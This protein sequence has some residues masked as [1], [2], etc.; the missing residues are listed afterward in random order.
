MGNL[1]RFV[2][3]VPYWVP[4]GT[5]QPPV[6]VAKIE[7]SR[8]AVRERRTS[9]GAG[10][11]RRFD[12]ESEPSGVADCRAGPGDKGQPS[13]SAISASRSGPRSFWI[14]SHAMFRST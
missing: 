5:Q 8:R 1:P 6:V 11:G 2:G 3:S 4:L 10:S 9:I 13:R 12:G 7:L 14:T